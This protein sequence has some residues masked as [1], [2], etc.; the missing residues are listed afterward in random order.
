[1]IFFRPGD[2]VQFRP[3]T[4]EEYDDDV[5]AFDASRIAPLIRPVRFSLDVFHADPQ[6]CNAVGGNIKAAELSGIDTRGTLLVAYGV[7]A[8]LAAVTGLLLTARVE[9][10]DANLG[11]SIALQSIAACVIGG[12]SL[13]GGIG[14]V[15]NVVLGAFFI[16]LTQNGMNLLQIG[17]HMQMV[18][19]GVLLIL[20][21]IADQV[22]YR[23]LLDAR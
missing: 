5:R 3:V 17:S 22:R 13:R 6:A 21:V 20:A 2:I 15:E 1:M 14:R 16:V 19:L 8:M 7:C 18:L 10:G 23:L 12:V 4:R 11:G 9:S